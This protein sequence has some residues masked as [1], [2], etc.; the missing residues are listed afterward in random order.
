MIA[1]LYS[2]I[3]LIITLI[4]FKNIFRINNIILQ[5]IIGTISYLGALIIFKEQLFINQVLKWIKR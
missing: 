4:I 2:G 1:Y 3:I 5:L